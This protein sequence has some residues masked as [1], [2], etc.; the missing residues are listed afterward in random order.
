[1]ASRKFEV[2]Q[3][4]NDGIEFQ[5]EFAKRAAHEAKMNEVAEEIKSVPMGILTALTKSQPSYSANSN[6]TGNSYFPPELLKPT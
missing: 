3:V 1:M 5:L 6:K 2:V 4:S